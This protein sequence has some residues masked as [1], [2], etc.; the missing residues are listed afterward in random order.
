MTTQEKAIEPIVRATHGSPNHPLR[1]GGI[2][3]P[4]YVLED[5]RRVLVQESMVK[6]LGMALGGNSNAAKR[7]RLVKF[8]A[9]KG[10]ELTAGAGGRLS[11][12]A[13]G[14]ALQPFVST[15]LLNTLTYPIKFRIPGGAIAHGYEAT[16]LAEICEVILKARDEGK[17]QKQQERIAK[18]ADILVRGFA[19]VGIIALVD[20]ATGYQAD[21]ARDALEEIL[22]KFIGVELRKWAKTF[23]DDFYFYLYKLK[24]LTYSDVSSKRPAFIGKVTNDIVYE[25]LAPGVLKELQ[26][27]TPKLESGRRKYRYHRWLTDDVGHP[28]LREHLASIIT[29]M[30]ASPN[31]ATFYRMLQRALPKYDDQMALPLPYDETEDEQIAE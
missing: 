2:E 20:E 1:I 29:L 24:G 21:R 22:K 15:E 8:A 18:Q 12:F 11:R 31:W 4:C 30:K 19:R 13:A 28:A 10:L 25:R 16:I 6:A 3:I 7:G 23:P 26:R 14:V 27:K 5:G 9:E 17:L